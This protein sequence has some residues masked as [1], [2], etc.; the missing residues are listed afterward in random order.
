MA[1]R[2]DDWFNLNTTR[3]YPFDDEA[4][5]I[6]DDAARLPDS[7]IVDATIGGTREASEHT[8]FL[9]SVSVSPL[10]VSAT[11]CRFDGGAGNTLV[12]FV[13]VDKDTAR[14]GTVPVEAVVP[15]FNGFISFGAAIASITDL[16]W[17]ASS[18]DQARFNER[19]VY[20]TAFGVFDDV[21]DAAAFSGVTGVIDLVTT[22]PDVLSISTGTVDG[23]N[24][25][26][27]GLNEKGDR[28]FSIHRNF[29]SPCDVSPDSNTCVVDS[30]TSINGIQ[31]TCA[32]GRITFNFISTAVDGSMNP[33]LDVTTAPA[34]IELSF[35]MSLETICNRVR[36]S[37]TRLPD[38]LSAAC[39]ELAGYDTLDCNNIC[40]DQVSVDPCDPVPFPGSPQWILNWV[41]SGGNFPTKLDFLLNR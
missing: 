21:T 40:V 23:K 16:N 20:Q 5:L 39:C 36:A 28:G 4:T 8:Y 15:N 19:C 29:I 2:I 35:N 26:F 37:R 27:I 32:D 25:I 7:I 9:G 12:G 1:V 31:P 11:I 13:N 17:A 10:I 3:R 6:G 38:I 18:V 22:N 34:T 14:R 24:A 41:A 30:I 33:L